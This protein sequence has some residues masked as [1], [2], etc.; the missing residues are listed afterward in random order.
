MTHKKQK[1]PFFYS[2]RHF[3]SYLTNSGLQGRGSN[4][5]QLPQSETHLNRLPSYH[6][7][8]L[9]HCIKN[10]IFCMLT[11][12]I[13]SLIHFVLAFVLM[14]P[15]GSILTHSRIVPSVEPQTTLERET[16]QSANSLNPASKKKILQIPIRSSSRGPTPPCKTQTP[17]G[18]A[19]R[20][21]RRHP[22]A[23][24]FNTDILCWQE[25]ASTQD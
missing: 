25:G 1:S 9:F 15:D 13:I 24:A 20:H 22:G 4:L 23:P 14:L 5:S 12:L 16:L 11:A 2:H 7:I 18:H 17:K 3:L 6:T 19:A 21:H 10:Q 8:P